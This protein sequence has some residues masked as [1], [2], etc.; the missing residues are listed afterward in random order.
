MIALR[1]TRPSSARGRFEHS[2]AD[3]RVLGYQ[4]RLGTE[5]TLVLINYGR[6]AKQVRVRGIAERA[7]LTPLYP[8]AAKAQRG[9]IITLAPRSVQVFDLR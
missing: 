6:E 8:A 1:N 5:R 9:P 2:F 3:G 4:R 7:A